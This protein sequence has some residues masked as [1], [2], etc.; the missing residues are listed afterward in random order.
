MLQNA[1]VPNDR[2]IRQIQSFIKENYREMYLK[3]SE[4]SDEGF[5]EG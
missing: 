4:L 5:Y 1:G 3:W 2:E